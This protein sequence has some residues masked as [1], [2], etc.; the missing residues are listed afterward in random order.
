[1]T[2]LV[3]TSVWV[4]HFRRGNSTLAGLLEEG[5]VVCHPFVIGELS[6]GDLRNR[7]EILSLLGALESA[8]IAENDE[9]LRFLKDEEL[10]R[11]GVGWIDVH[12]LAST[13]LMPCLLWTLDKA[14]RSI[15]EELQVAAVF[16]ATP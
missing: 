4:D 3:D 15:A 13:R 7:E 2:V 5:R 10:Q 16:P 6:C 11:R 1:M 12:L 8:P 9:A 14:L